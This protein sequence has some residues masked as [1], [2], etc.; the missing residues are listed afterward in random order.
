[1]LADENFEDQ[2]VD[3][4][5]G[6]E[7]RHRSDVLAGLSE[8]V[9]AALTLLVAGRV[10]GQVVVDDGTEVLLEVDALRQAVCSDQD[11]AATLV[12]Q[13]ADLLPA[14]LGVEGAGDGRDMGIPVECGGE[15]AGHVLGGRNVAAEDDRIVPV[16]EQRLYLIGQSAQLGVVLRTGQGGS[17]LG[18][19]VHAAGVGAVGGG[20]V[21][22]FACPGS[23]GVVEAGAGDGVDAFLCLAPGEFQDGLASDSVGLL[24]GVGCGDGGALGQCGRRSVRRGEHTAQQGEHRPPAHALPQGATGASDFLAGERHD[25]GDEAS[26]VLVEPVRNV[27]ELTVSWERGVLAE[28]RADVSAAALHHVPGEAVAVSGQCGIELPQLWGEQPGE[29]CESG[30]IS[31]VRGGGDQQQVPLRVLGEAGQQSIPQLIAAAGAD[32][33]VRLVH[34]EQ[35]RAGAQE[36]LTAVLLLDEVSGDDRVRK[37][38]EDRG[39]GVVA[40]AL[41]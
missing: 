36:R 34:D 26:V 1:M 18:E 11:V 37:V 24:R 9:H 8:A 35:V 13:L 38:T 20:L 39:I 16:D 29:F 40:D 22:A 28:E 19:R 32:A 4:G 30:G 7:E 5:V 31:A 3:A 14:G 10:P 2:A 21:V 6:V 25:I 15:V 23:L 27:G 17:T 12:G 41:L 33:G